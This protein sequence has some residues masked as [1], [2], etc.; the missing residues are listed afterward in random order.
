LRNRCHHHLKTFWAGDWALTLR[1]DGAAI[2]TSPV[3]QIFTTQPGCRMFFPNWDIT[4]AE[5]PSPP[6]PPADIDRGAR[7]PLRKRTRA[8]RIKAE[9][10]HKD[11][12]PPPV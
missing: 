1:P 9:R 8:A 3:G 11:S 4:T 10:A 2:W 6:S 7:M 12:D 5:L